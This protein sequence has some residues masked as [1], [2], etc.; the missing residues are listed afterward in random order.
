MIASSS[1]KS[2]GLIR[3][4]YSFINGPVEIVPVNI[5]EMVKF[6]NNS[7]HALKITFANEVG[8]I[9]KEYGIDSHQM[10]DLF[11]KDEILN[12]SPAYLKPGFAYGG[13][14]LP[15]DLAGLVMMGRQTG[16]TTPVLSAIEQSNEYHKEKAFHMVKELNKK[17]VGLIGLSFKEGT[18]DLRFSPAVDL[19]KK[20][21]GE[22][23]T[24]SIYDKSVDLAKLIGGNKSYIKENLPH[25]GKLVSNNLNKVIED[26]EVVIVNQKNIDYQPYLSH[27]KNKYIIDLAR[28]DLLRDSCE[29]Y[30]GINW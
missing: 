30:E 4:L 12:I 14:C 23:Y 2:I 19:A 27:L 8:N 6:L 22:G 21:I 24:L 15:K 7:W 28:V 1:N 3:E 25:I 26:S 17:R 16:L 9:C 5:A 13:S 18:D 11:V 10:M 20:L 29:N